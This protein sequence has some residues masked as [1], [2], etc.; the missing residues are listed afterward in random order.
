MLKAELSLSPVPDAREYVNVSPT[1]GSVVV[2][3]PMVVLLSEFSAI[4]VLESW[5]S[6]GAALE[7]TTGMRSVLSNG[8]LLA[9]IARTR[10][11]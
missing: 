4:E 1:F 5:M 9:S 7:F 8:M 2:R 6:T 3:L 10:I 11:E